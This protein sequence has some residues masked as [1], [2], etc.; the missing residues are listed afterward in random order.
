M[1]LNVD[2]ISSTIPDMVSDIAYISY[3]ITRQ[4]KKITKRKKKRPNICVLREPKYH[5]G[6]Y[7]FWKFPYEFKKSKR[8]VQLQH[9]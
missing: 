9:R 5:I 2:D 8:W 1:T 3:D 6:Q 7:F 4:K